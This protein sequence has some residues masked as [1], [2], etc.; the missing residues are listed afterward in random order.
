MVYRKFIT[1]SV[2]IKKELDDA[3]KITYKLKFIDSF[4]FMSTSLTK[5]AKYLSERLHNDKCTYCKSK[6]DYMAFK[7]D[8]LIF[9]CFECKNNYWKNFNKE[10]IN[11][12]ANTCEFYNGNINECVLLLRIGV[13]P[14]EHMGSWE[15][16]D[17]TSLSDKKAFYIEWYLKDTTHAQKVFKKFKFKNHDLYVQSDTLLLADVLENCE[18]NVL[19]YMNLIQLIFCLHLD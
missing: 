13:H 1:F 6:L 18:T 11:R 17:E 15:R 3:K 9:R 19:K 8:Q 14:Y 10:V 4:R 2:S 12:F 5:L 7:D 16:F